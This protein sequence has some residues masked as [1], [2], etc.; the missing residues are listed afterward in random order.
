MLDEDDIDDEGDEDEYD[1]EDEDDVDFEDEDEQPPSPAQHLFAHPFW[2]ATAST[3]ERMRRCVVIY[4]WIAAACRSLPKRLQGNAE[5][6]IG[7]LNYWFRP[8][9]NGRLRAT[10]R[11]DGYLWVAKTDEELAHECLLP[12]YRVR[13]ALDA[14]LEHGFIVR[15]NWMFRT[16]RTGHFRFVWDALQ[17][18]ALEDGW[19]EEDEFIDADGSR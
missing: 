13:R 18:A 17:G 11:R 12:L 16:Q 5:K 1:D 7:A 4:P 10:I 14:L 3:G 8:G 2:R 6:V 9:S 19:D 15:R